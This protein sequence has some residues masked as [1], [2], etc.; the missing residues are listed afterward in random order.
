MRTFPVLPDHLGS[1]AIIDALG[2]NDP[3]DPPADGSDFADGVVAAAHGAGPGF[4]AVATLLADDGFD[5]STGPV[6][7]QY[8]DT[9]YAKGGNGGGNG[10]GGNGGG[11]DGGGS[12]DPVLSEY[13]SGGADGDAGFDILIDFKGSGWTADL[14]QAFIDAADYLTSVITNDT[15]P[16]TRYRGT[17]IDDLYIT[18][19]LSDIDGSGGILGQAGPTATWTASDLTAAGVMQFDIADAFDYASAGLWDEIVF[20][21]MMHVVGFGS[22]WDFERDLAPL[23]VETGEYEYIGQNGLDAY[24]ASLDPSADYIPVESSGFGAGT[25]G[26]H[27]DEDALGNEL[28]TGFIDTSNYVSEFSIVS[29]ADLGYVVAYADYPYDEVPLV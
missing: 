27:W 28:M 29:L 24:N 12:G 17:N 8:K 15:G 7:E 10:K 13:A 25:D 3:F 26:S 20:H 2:L 9:D 5:F 18:A 1:V 22:L 4:D 11:H 19:E 14:Q 16:G 23:N 21:E 6:I